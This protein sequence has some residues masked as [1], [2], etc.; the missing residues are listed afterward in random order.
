V[1]SLQDRE[2]F[3]LFKYALEWKLLEKSNKVRQPAK[4]SKK[5]PQNKTNQENI[6][7]V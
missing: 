6:L 1:F 7:P 5:K 3:P 4:M 2:I